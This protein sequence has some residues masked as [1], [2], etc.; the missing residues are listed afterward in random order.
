[1]A[2]V[3][4]EHPCLL[5]DV[6]DGRKKL[7][8][9]GVLAKH[10]PEHGDSPVQHFLDG[11]EVSIT[12]SKEGHRIRGKMGVRAN[13]P[14]NRSNK[15]AHFCKGERRGFAAIEGKGEDERADGTMP[16]SVFPASAGK[17]LANAMPCNEPVTN[18]GSHHAFAKTYVSAKVSVMQNHSDVAIYNWPHMILQPCTSG[19]TGGEKETFGE[20]DAR[21]NNVKIEEGQCV[22]SK[23]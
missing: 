17:F 1:M 4:A 19:S 11:I 21:A 3:G 22:A 10:A 7:I 5:V 9:L 13:V 6:V 15:F 23:E 8:E 14:C 18:G 2:C 12:S 20:R 16:G